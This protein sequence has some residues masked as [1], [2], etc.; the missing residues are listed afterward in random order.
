VHAWRQVPA[1][2]GCPYVVPV[3]R[4][5][6]VPDLLR[7]GGGVRRGNG[8]VQCQLPGVSTAQCLAGVPTAR[9]PWQRQQPQRLTLRRGVQSAA[10]RG[11]DGARLPR[12]ISSSGWDFGHSEVRAKKQNFQRRGH[13]EKWQ[14]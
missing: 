1:R 8:A 6:C 2:R 3:R 10:V 13:T 12:K 9:A 14:S 4:V 11:Q 7:C 5:A